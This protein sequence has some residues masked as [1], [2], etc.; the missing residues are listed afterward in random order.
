MKLCPVLMGSLYRK[1]EAVPPSR[2]KSQVR[3]LQFVGLGGGKEWHLQSPQ[4][5]NRGLGFTTN[6]DLEKGGGLGPSRAA[7]T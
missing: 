7:L 1:A 4:A 6:V 2:K 5:R 3:A